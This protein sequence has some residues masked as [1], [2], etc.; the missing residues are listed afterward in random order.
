[1]KTNA[2]A[3]EKFI[4]NGGA[5]LG[6]HVSAYNDKDTKWP[7]FVDFLGGGVFYNNNWPPWL[8]S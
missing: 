2:R 6:F 3:F 4:N 5:W 1:M 8:Q 7:W